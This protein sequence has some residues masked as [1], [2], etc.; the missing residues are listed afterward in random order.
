MDINFTSTQQ[1]IGGFVG[2]GNNVV[3]NNCFSTGQ[4]NGS[5]AGGLFGFISGS[6]SS[7][8]NCY[9]RCAISGGSG[10]REGGLGGYF[11][12]GEIQNSYSTGL[13][14]GGSPIGGLF[15]INYATVTDCFWDTETSE[16]SSSPNGGTGK[17]TAD[18]KDYTTF[19]NAGWDF[20]VETANGTTNYWDI[21]NAS[22]V[23]NS[24]YPFLAWEN[25]DEVSL[26][27]NIAPIADD[28][29]VTTD[30]DV[31]VAIT[32]TGSDVDGDVLTFAVVTAPTNGTLTGDT[33]NL[34]YTPNTGYSGLDSFTYVANDG[35]VD[36]EEASVTI[37]VNEALTAPIA[38]DDIVSTDEDVPYILSNLLT[39]DS[40]PNG[41]EISIA[42]YT[43][44]TNGAI[45]F[46]SIETRRNELPNKIYWTD[47]DEYYIKRSNLDGSE[48]EELISSE[49]YG[50][51]LD[52]TNEHMYFWDYDA[53][54]IY[55]TNLDATEGLTDIVDVYDCY[56]IALDI[57][58]GKIYYA[59]GDN[60]CLWRANLDGSGAE[61]ILEDVEPYSITIDAQNNQL[62]FWD[63]ESDYIV[64]C[65]LDG[66][67]KESI[68]EAEGTSNS[69]AFDFAN[70]KMYFGYNGEMAGIFRANL[71]GSEVEPVIEDVY[72]YQLDLDLVNN[73]IYF[74]VEEEATILAR[75]NLD[76]SEP[77]E[78]NWVDIYSEGVLKLNSSNNA[79][80]LA[81]VPNENWFGTD[82]FTYTI[83]DG[84]EISEEA[85]V[86]ITVNSVNDF[87]IVE[88]VWL[89]TQPN[90]AVSTVLT[91][92]DVESDVTLSIYEEPLNGTLSGE[93]PNI[94]YTPN[95]DWAGS[96]Y[97]TYRAFDGINYSSLGV[98]TVIVN[99]APIVENI[100]FT[101]NEDVEISIPF[102]GSDVNGDD[103]TFEVVDVP[104]MGYVD[105]DGI[106]Y[107][108]SNVNGEDVF[109]YLANDGFVN[110]EIATAT[111]TIVAVNDTPEASD[112][113]FSAFTNNQSNIDVVV[114]DVDEDELAYNILEEPQHGE[115]TGVAPNFIY[116]PQNDYMGTDS[117]VL[118]VSDGELQTNAIITIG[119]RNFLKWGLH[120]VGDVIPADLYHVSKVC[121]GNDF[122]LA[123]LP[124]STVTGWGRNYYNQITPPDGLSGVID[125]DA[126]LYHSIALKSDGTV[127]VWGLNNQEQCNV[128]AD[129]DSVVVIDAGRFHNAVVKSDGSVVVWGAY[130][131]PEVQP[132]AGLTDII[133]IATSTFNV[134]ALKSDGTVIGWGNNENNLLN[135]PA[136]LTDVV[137]ISMSTQSAYALKSDGTIVAWG[138]NFHGTL[139]IPTDITDFVR[140]KAGEYHCLAQRAD[141]T[142]LAWGPN[143]YGET[144]I[145]ENVM[146]VTDLSA[147]MKY[148]YGMINIDVNSNTAPV[149]NAGVDVSIYEG[150]LVTLDA[151]GSSDADGDVITY[152]WTAPEGVILSDETAIN[153]TFTA[154]SVDVDVE[155]T[156]SLVVNDGEFDSNVDEVV[157]TV[158]AESIPAGIEIVAADNGNNET[159]LN[160]TWG[161]VEGLQYY[162]YK[163]DDAYAIYPD[164]W[165][166]LNADSP[167]T[168]G[169]FSETITDEIVFYRLA[170]ELS[171]PCEVIGYVRYA[172]SNIPSGGR[173]MIALPFE[174]TLTTAQ[175]LGESIPNCDAVAKWDAEAQLWVTAELDDGWS[176]SFAI[177]NNIAYMVNVTSTTNVYF[178]GTIVPDVNYE[179]ITTAGTNQN[180]I[181]LPLSKSS[182]NTASAVGNDIGVSKMISKW[183]GAHQGW[184]STVKLPFGWIS[185]FVVDVALPLLVD[186]TANTTWPEIPIFTSNVTKKENL[187]FIRT[188]IETNLPNPVYGQIFAEDGISFIAE[189]D[190][191]IY[192]YNTNN[193]E[194]VINLE[195]YGC[196]YGL[197][198]GSNP[199]GYEGWFYFEV[200][201]FQDS[202]ATNDVIRVVI[203]EQSTGYQIMKEFV[204]TVD[205]DN[206]VNTV[207][208]AN[209]I[210]LETDEDTPVTVAFVGSDL[211]ND[212]L[213]FSVVDAPTNGVYVD[214]VYTPNAGWFGVDT[215]TY[216]ANDGT[217]D[218]EIATVTITVNEVLG[219]PS[220]PTNV[221]IVVSVDDIGHVIRT[222]TWNPVPNVDFYNVYACDT[223][224]GNFVQINQEPII[225]TTFESVG[226]SV[227]KFYY[228]TANNGGVV[229]ISPRKSNFRN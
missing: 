118:E 36:S 4:V 229:T 121:A 18:M 177:E 161:V 91:G 107:P 166:C 85:S 174:T 137:G 184:K 195:T 196:G 71:D 7:I 73:K 129:L 128:P 142:I 60:Y 152:L 46:A 29:A 207:P 145:P 64:K 116:T 20:E 228:V 40:D 79:G 160:I 218:S 153:P 112:Q 182:L 106:Y 100:V 193:S 191:E 103:L 210:S 110:S 135:I 104:T 6:N 42:S 227:M 57:L 83:T 111:V 138:V 214:G 66:S 78:L 204:L 88:N 173:N 93:I 113:I 171:A 98:I 189:D 221:Q 224:D 94:T 3:M 11:A 139:D 74:T 5:Q 215:F 50:L 124:D 212:E 70:S 194:D 38:V 131:V 48:V 203:T 132:P 56:S 37:T 157:V 164:E 197:G 34:T 183:N 87:P 8:T 169:T 16:Q 144:T 65:N 101:T 9:S 81:Y 14:T 19:T 162:I 143:D 201:N 176:N 217:V 72:V 68:L 114:S 76:G 127:A 67:E 178:M 53:D 22:G 163:S 147:G 219:A 30:E 15:G 225:G 45:T 172:C 39:N 211:D 55:R 24:G 89:S 209:D 21:D 58:N 115:L 92:S 109:T 99:D 170:T 179:L 148:N 205:G 213:T 180:T 12:A 202:W 26:H 200:A 17:T 54:T 140:I 159:L 141:D 43:Q 125:V 223:P 63:Y 186:V 119:T 151:S 149:A 175:E 220:A 126:G 10:V 120:W 190:I 27:I 33:P 44:P 97:F 49:V 95:L 122:S 134:I 25:G 77:E 206:P 136:D 117:F 188:P 28:I 13:V 90:I 41:D 86:T 130:W 82:S 168:S 61:I 226:G 198:S 208:V 123:I 80:V 32:L 2:S 150:N 105:G 154:P 167:N 181:M 47:H 216:V 187:T 51:A 1:D 155:Y 146:G 52:M 75:C 31:A 69:L 84:S 192:A 23:I 35:T 199:P 222:I 59:D 96:D 133:D 108:L 158:L 185:N 165:I 102:V 62:Y 156:F